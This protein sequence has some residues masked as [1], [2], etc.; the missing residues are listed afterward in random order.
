MTSRSRIRK[1]ACTIAILLLL[2]LLLIPTALLLHALILSSV[3]FFFG[4][5]TCDL[6]LT[7]CFSFLPLRGRYRRRTSDLP[8]IFLRHT[9]EQEGNASRCLHCRMTAYDGKTVI[10]AAYHRISTR[11]DDGRNNW[12]FCSM[13]MK[14]RTVVETGEKILL[15]GPRSELCLGREKH[16]ETVRI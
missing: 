12:D 6:K 16:E 9:E 14:A 7:S 1:A 10:S 3:F 5:V 2:A 15:S 13:K 8:K 11:G 4:P